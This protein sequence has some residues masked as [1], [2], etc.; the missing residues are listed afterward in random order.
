M[1]DI[2]MSRTGNYAE[3]WQMSYARQMLVICKIY[4][5]TIKWDFTETQTL[6]WIEKFIY[7]E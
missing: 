2:I 4:L 7:F 6:P 1:F 3:F 5:I